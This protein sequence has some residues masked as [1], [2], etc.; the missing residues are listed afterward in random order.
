MAVENGWGQGAVNNT[1]DYGKA[2][3]NST[4]GF[5]KI[6]ETS[7]AGLTNIIGGSPAPPAL[8]QVDNVYSMSFD[9][10]SNIDI[11]LRPAFSGAQFTWSFWINYTS[12]TTRAIYSQGSTSLGFSSAPY[13]AVD[14][15]ALRIWL[16]TLYSTG[17]G[18][19]TKNQWQ[20]VVAT[21]DSSSV[22]R[23]YRNGVVFDSAGQVIGG[24]QPAA[25]GFIG[26]W[27]SSLGP[28]LFFTGKI[29]EA[30]IW[31]IALTDAEILSIYN[32]TAVVDGV[33]KTA[34]LNDLTT[35]PVAWY[36]M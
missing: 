5:G 23:L 33:N 16:G 2:K 8:A 13:L 18:F 9:G 10:T 27:V 24:S 7:N 17:T 22:V 36:R 29:D 4:N 26:S 14:G 32:A 19:L 31:D 28:G 35:P 6:Y 3:A 1:N 12:S 11:G 34:D 15:T 20:H 21:R 30:A 25:N